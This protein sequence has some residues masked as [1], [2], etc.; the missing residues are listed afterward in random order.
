MHGTAKSA[1]PS[2]SSAPVVAS[3]RWMPAA[4]GHGSRSAVHASAIGSEM[5]APSARFTIGPWCVSRISSGSACFP[6]TA[7][8]SCVTFTGL[9][10]PSNSYAAP[11]PSCAVR[12][13]STYRSWTSAMTF[14]KLHA[15]HG[16]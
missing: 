13:R 11:L 10:S 4:L 14:V 12:T 15:T 16:L 5:V 3:P 1:R 6:R 9:H 7:I 2:T 8:R